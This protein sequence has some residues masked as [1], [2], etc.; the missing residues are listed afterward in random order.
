MALT[1]KEVQ[2]RMMNRIFA[3]AKEVIVDLQRGSQDRVNL[4]RWVRNQLCTVAPLFA[5]G[6]RA[7]V[8][9]GDTEDTEAVSDERWSAVLAFS[10]FTELF[11]LLKEYDLP[12][13]DS[14]FWDILPA[15]LRRPWFT[16]IWVLQEYSLAQ[17]VRFMI[18]THSRDEHFLE[19]AVIRA[20]YH[21]HWLYTYNR[22]YSS[23]ESC[24][25][26]PLPQLEK[27]IGEIQLPCRGI[28]QLHKARHFKS[29]GYSLCELLW[30]TN[31]VFKAT[32]IRDKVYALIGICSDEKIN[33]EFEIRI[34]EYLGRRGR[35]DYALYNGIGD[36]PGYISWARDFENDTKDELSALVEAS[37]RTSLRLFQAGGTRW[38]SRL[39]DQRA[40]ALFVRGQSID[41]IDSC[42]R[43]ALPNTKSTRYDLWLKAVLKWI[44]MF[45]LLLSQEYRDERV[46]FDR[47]FEWMLSVVHKQSLPEHEFV[48]NCWRTLIADLI[49]GTGQEGS[50]GITRLR[51]WPHSD[52][53][54]KHW[55]EC[56]RLYY[57]RRAGEGRKEVFKNLPAETGSDA[58]VYGLSLNYAYGRKLALSRD[59]KLPCLIPADARVGDELVIVG[60]CPIPFILRR[61]N[62]KDGKGDYFPMVGCV[63]VH[64][65]MDGEAAPKEP[66]CESIEIW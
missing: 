65:I 52:R 37:G 27:A 20:A 8:D 21:L 55:A 34:H 41:V 57:H 23:K 54:L 44:P 15:F 40:G 42:M 10:N 1:E 39:S 24:G 11:V 4:S 19:R 12:R 18:G 17:K 6:N 32:D 22:L 58:R 14:P 56:M 66:N 13:G 51:D 60:G 31:A 2:V 7:V 49:V 25:S 43:T 35:G 50:R 26:G 38:L 64:G 53:C 59:K 36:K 61:K 46:W 33:E 47:A 45:E 3:G 16:R 30:S 63:Y 62:D 48:D 29:A 9:V 5:A 28:Q